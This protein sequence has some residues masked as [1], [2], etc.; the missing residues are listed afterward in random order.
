LQFALPK[1][2][3]KLECKPLASTGGT[4]RWKGACLEKGACLKPVVVFR[5]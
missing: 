5:F 1:L 4:D 2:E 3:C